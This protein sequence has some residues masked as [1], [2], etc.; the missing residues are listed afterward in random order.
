MM[1]RF[2]ILS[3]LVAF[4]FAT[5]FGCAHR[6]IARSSSSA[7]L[8]EIIETVKGLGKYQNTVYNVFILQKRR[9]CV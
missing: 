8:T 1:T 4:S 6:D 7:P 9:D 3:C 5:L 2:S